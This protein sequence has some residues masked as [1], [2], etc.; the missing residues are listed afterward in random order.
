MNVTNDAMTFKIFTLIT[1]GL[2]SNVAKLH[3]RSL[4]R[5]GEINNNVLDRRLLLNLQALHCRN[6]AKL[7]T[8]TK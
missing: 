7:E 3:L 6:A 1:S 8:V 5:S 4:H 2:G